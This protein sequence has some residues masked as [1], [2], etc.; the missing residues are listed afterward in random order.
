M[1]I[2]AE[3]ATELLAQARPLEPS[4]ATRTNTVDQDGDLTAGEQHAT[5]AASTLT[6][7]RNQ[8]TGRNPGPD[9][10]GAHPEV[11]DHLREA[12]QHAIGARCHGHTL[13]VGESEG[14]PFLLSHVA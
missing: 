5:S 13:S 1:A 10:S 7:N 9:G 14:K 8:A 2:A 6:A 11:L 12:H 3:A 4:T